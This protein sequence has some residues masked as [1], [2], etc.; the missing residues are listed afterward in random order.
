[1]AGVWRWIQNPYGIPEN[2]E[3]TN[4]IKTNDI[5]FEVYP[6]PVIDGILYLKFDNNIDNRSQIQIIDITG[7]VLYQEET[8][9]LLLGNDF[10][11]MSQF[12][13]GIYFIQL[14]SGKKKNPKKIIIK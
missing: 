10:I 11:D 4:I 2:S 12:I 8:S 13:P 3:A 5:Q 1:M 6:N 7:H 9:N 14:I